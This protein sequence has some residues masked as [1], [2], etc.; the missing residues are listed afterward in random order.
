[1]D[2]DNYGKMVLYKFPSETIYSPILFKQKINQD[3]IIS[4]KYHFG[5]HKVLKFI[6][7]ETLIIPIKNS[8]FMLNL[9]I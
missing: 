4:K 2:G 1:M 7:G 9:C 3:T 5:I 6:Y 8:L